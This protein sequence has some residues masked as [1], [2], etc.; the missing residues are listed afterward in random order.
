MDDLIK[1]SRAAKE[2]TTPVENEYEELERYF[3]DPLVR[4]EACA[5]PIAWWG[6]S[7]C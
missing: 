2:T 4:K 1:S 7:V 3:L 5:D 6:V